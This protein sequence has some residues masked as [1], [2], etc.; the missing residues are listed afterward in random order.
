MSLVMNFLLNKKVLVLSVLSVLSVLFF[1]I[2]LSSFRVR[3]VSKDD[4]VNSRSYLTIELN[5]E[6]KNAESVEKTLV[7]QPSVNLVVFV[8]KNLIIIAPLNKYVNGVEYTIE[9]PTI[10]SVDDS[11]IK[12]F[13]TSFQIEKERPDELPYR[14]DRLLI[15]KNLHKMWFLNESWVFNG[16]CF[17]LEGVNLDSTSPRLYLLL[18]PDNSINLFGD[19]Y[20]IEYDKCFN[21]FKIFT[22][23]NNIKLEEVF[24]NINP[25]NLQYRYLKNNGY[26]SSGVGD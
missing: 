8:K 22:E 16:S 19:N 7:V 1:Y 20:F 11:V 5:K 12:G 26:D 9:I 13:K 10:I 4:P 15:E 3:S 14:I 24:L 25:P 17:S 21:E 6:I 18:K 2:R 23:K